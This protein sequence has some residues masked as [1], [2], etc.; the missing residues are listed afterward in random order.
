MCCK[1][2][3]M[4]HKLCWFSLFFVVILNY[5]SL[6][7]GE[8]FFDVKYFNKNSFLNLK[9]V[10]NVSYAHLTVVKSF[11]DLTLNAFNYS[12]TRNKS[13]E[14]RLVLVFL[15]IQ[16]TGG[17]LIERRLTMSSFLGDSK[18]TCFDVR[19]RRCS[20]LNKKG[21][22]WLVSRYVFILYEMIWVLC[23]IYQYSLYNY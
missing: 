23:Y 17:T 10:F 21:L 13:E 3:F 5:Y 6:F 15:H 1:F 2:S 16:K 12:K 18:C 14:D 22:R 19:R 11:A 20:C 7:Y 9:S 8:N 4:K